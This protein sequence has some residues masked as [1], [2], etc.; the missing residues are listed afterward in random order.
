MERRELLAAMSMLAVRPHPLPTPIGTVRA[1]DLDRLRLCA[2]FVNA[3]MP[4]RVWPD[5]GKLYLDWEQRIRLLWHDR[6]YMSSEP[7]RLVGITDSILG[8]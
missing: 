7:V 3:A 8:D 6:V 4:E 2:D 5:S 1:V